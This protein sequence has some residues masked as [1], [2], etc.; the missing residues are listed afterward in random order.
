MFP[1]LTVCLS[2]RLSAF[3]CTRLSVFCSAYCINFES[4]SLS[5]PFFLLRCGFALVPNARCCCACSVCSA[6][7]ACFAC[8]VWN[9]VHANVKIGNRVFRACNRLCDTMVLLHVRTW[10]KLPVRTHRGL[11]GAAVRSVLGRRC[12]ECVR[13]AK[14][15]IG[16]EKL[17]W[18][19]SIRVSA[20]W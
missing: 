11:F 18:S 7:C 12:T 4:S 10:N 17:H 15:C 5:F 2:T 14:R 1:C 6:C 19:T 16:E 9:G 3:M 8:S 20:G 13:C